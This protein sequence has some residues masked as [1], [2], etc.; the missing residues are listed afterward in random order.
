MDE[1]LY[2]YQAPSPTTWVYLSSLLTIAIYFKFSRV[3][4]VRNFDLL[5]LIAMAPGLLITAHGE[6]S[7]STRVEHYGYIW[8]FAAGG[9][10]LVRLL[11]DSA[12]VRRPLLEPNLSQ[13]GLT[14]SGLALL[15][16]LMANV[17]TK[18]VAPDDMKTA[19]QAKDLV[20]LS[21]SP[22]PGDL[23]RQGPGYP[24]LWV[25]PAISTGPL[26]EATQ[27]QSA[28]SPSAD[29]QGR[30]AFAAT[31][32]AMAILSHLAI[33]LGM[34]LIG[35]LHFDNYRTGIAAAVLY[36]LL[37]Y[38]TQSTGRVDHVLPAALLIWTVLAYR[39]PLT[40]GLLL[41]LATGAVYYPLFLLPLWVGFYWNKGLR[42]FVLG[43]GATLTALVASLAFMPPA[44]GSFF[45]QVKQMFGWANLSSASAEGFWAFSE[46]AYPFRLVVMAAFSL[47]CVVFALWPLQ[48]NLGTLL[49]CSSA[50]MLGTQYWHAQ[51]GGVHLAWH[52]P[53]LLLTIFRPN[54]DD[55][56]AIGTFDLSWFAR[57]RRTL[58]NWAA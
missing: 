40:A 38:T 25:L 52:L 28:E 47:M 16:F 2:Q 3:L 57:Q 33:V 49:S 4:S 32:R 19:E 13:G 55:R 5:A 36:L 1:I 23:A 58:R 31:A 51:G 22:P 6:Q 56:V 29:E 20:D 42:R 50:V 14:F 18:N 35:R 9:V 46:A 34:V 43:Y 11:L 21:E 17:A 15:A 48:K 39:N 41:G 10:F 53:L 7:G 12:M 26:L 37:P 30:M 27:P 45:D 8:T 44:F 54:L 24:W